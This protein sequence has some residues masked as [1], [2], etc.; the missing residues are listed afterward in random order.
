M[1]DNISELTWSK[2]N[3]SSTDKRKTQ[4]RKN[5]IIQLSRTEL[6]LDSISK[7]TDS[8][9]VRHRTIRLGCLGV[10]NSSAMLLFIR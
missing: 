8:S 5:V 1:M 6:E 7:R 2:F 4:F 10:S 3:D 9:R